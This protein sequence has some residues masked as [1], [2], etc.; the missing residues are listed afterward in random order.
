M[1]HQPQQHPLAHA[2]RLALT[3]TLAAAAM[4]AFAQDAAP[5]PQEKEATTLER[6]EVT[7]SRIKR[8]DIETSQPVFSLS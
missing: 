4:P 1:T 3:S 7:G 2:L 5:A 6:I 8:T